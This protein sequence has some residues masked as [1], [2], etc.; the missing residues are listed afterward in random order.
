MTKHQKI[1]DTACSSLM[2]AAVESYLQGKAKATCSWEKEVPPTS[3]HLAGVSDLDPYPHRGER[4]SRAL[5]AG[6]SLSY[7]NQ[8]KKKQKNL[9]VR[10]R[11]ARKAAG[12]A[13][14][15]QGPL[16]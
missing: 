7:K 8:A 5:C 14:Q 15:E 13:S 10:C 3:H 11:S 4:E 2:S 6:E 16:I 12:V 1:R 9:C